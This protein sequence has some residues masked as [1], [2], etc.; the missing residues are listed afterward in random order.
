MARGGLDRP[1]GGSAATWG[2]GGAPAAGRRPHVLGSTHTPVPNFEHWVD[3]NGVA[4]VDTPSGGLWVPV[5][6]RQAWHFAHL[7]PRIRTI[8]R[9]FSAYVGTHTLLEASR[10]PYST[11]G[12][13]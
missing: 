5:S 9:A 13:P 1:P 4:R 8:C 10:A 2:G 7:F 6:A 11:V 12:G 3:K